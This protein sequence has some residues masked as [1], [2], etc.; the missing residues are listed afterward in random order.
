MLK[1]CMT[2]F[3]KALSKQWGKDLRFLNAGC[4]PQSISS[5]LIWSRQV[6]QMTVSHVCLSLPTCLLACLQL[7]KHF[8]KH[9]SHF[10]G[11]CVFTGNLGVSSPVVTNAWWIPN[12][13]RQFAAFTCNRL[14]CS[15]CPSWS[16][17]SCW[18]YELTYL[19]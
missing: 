2:V 18:N 11:G 10:H 8:S 12:D 6:L 3:I 4:E 14:C 5:C 15:K 13:D 16:P 9:R 19:H 7:E 1:V 17:N